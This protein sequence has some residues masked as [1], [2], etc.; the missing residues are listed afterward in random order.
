M[1]EFKRGEKMAETPSNKTIEFTRGIAFPKKETETI[2]EFKRGERI[3]TSSTANKVEISRGIA[4]PKK[5]SE[6]EV[7]KDEFVKGGRIEP[8]PTK[9]TDTDSGFSRG[10]RIVKEEPKQNK[11]EGFTRGKATVPT[12]TNNTKAKEPEKKGGDDKWG[13]GARK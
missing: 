12:I 13:R 10:S 6:K 7:K 8:Q 5:E 1:P 3:D 2:P 9:Q 11:D 4:F